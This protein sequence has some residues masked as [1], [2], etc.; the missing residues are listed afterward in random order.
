MEW[1]GVVGGLSKNIVKTLST[2]KIKFY[3][4]YNTYIRMSKESAKSSDVSDAPSLVPFL[5]ALM[6][7]I[8]K[9]FLTSI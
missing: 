8:F 4:L 2:I 6:I 3:R 1:V 5:V 7:S 9:A